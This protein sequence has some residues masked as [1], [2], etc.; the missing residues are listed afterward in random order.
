MDQKGSFPEK[1]QGT[2]TSW[3]SDIAPKLAKAFE[4]YTA[5]DLTDPQPPSKRVPPTRL[6]QLNDVRVPV[7]VIHGDH[8][9]AWFRQFDDTLM[10]CLPKAKRVIIANG[11]HGAHFAQP[12]EFNRAVLQFLETVR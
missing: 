8:E 9:L 11:G 3:R 12:D 7:L 6:A 2:G 1:I 5:R 4:G 10:A